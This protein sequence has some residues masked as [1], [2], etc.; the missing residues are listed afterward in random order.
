M[1]GCIF[2]KI[3]QREIPAQVV[4]EDEAILAF[5]DVNPVAPVHV[6]IIPKEHIA[7]VLSL[8]QEHSEIIKGIWLVIPKL[9]QELGIADR[10]FRVVVN[11]GPAAGQSVPHLH[12]HLLGGRALSWPPG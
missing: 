2:C 12:F 6:L 5:K 9:A 1:E 11:S 7:G 10:G 8:N 4:Y 3:V